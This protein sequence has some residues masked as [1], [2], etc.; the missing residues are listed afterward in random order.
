MDNAPITLRING[1]TCEVQASLYDTLLTIL[2]DKLLLTSA[3]RGC[4]QGV[5]GACT[6]LA[7]GVPVRACLSLA[8]DC[9]EREIETLDG[10]CDESCMQALQRSFVAHGAFQCGF[11]TPGMLISA[12]ALL[13]RKPSLTEADA[14]KAL[15]GNLCRCTGYKKIIEAVV[16][17]AGELRG[18]AR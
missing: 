18:D 3:K 2:R 1:A 8:L 17:A 9:E 15:S 4:N 14:R 5:C 7:D 12:V 16:D 6:V 10:L 11:C 13:R